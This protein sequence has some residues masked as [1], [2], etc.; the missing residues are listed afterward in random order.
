MITRHIFTEIAQF[1][2]NT[3]P[4]SSP[5]SQICVFGRSTQVGVIFLCVVTRFSLYW[6]LQR[7]ASHP[8]IPNHVQSSSLLLLKRLLPR[9]PPIGLSSCLIGQKKWVTCLL[10]T[11]HCQRALDGHSQLLLTLLHPLGLGA[12]ILFLSPRLPTRCAHSHV[13]VDVCKMGT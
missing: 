13:V 12:G 4:P 2:P 1:D 5:D 10:E 11:N 9:K 3:S 8:H 7:Q 6:L